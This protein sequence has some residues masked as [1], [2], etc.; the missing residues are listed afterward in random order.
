MGR[1]RADRSADIAVALPLR[2]Q[3]HSVAK[4]AKLLGWSFAKA[5]RALAQAKERTEASAV[6]EAPKEKEPKEKRKPVRISEVVEHRTELPRGIVHRIIFTS[7]QDDTPVHKPFWDN[8]LV[9]ANYLQAEIAVG[10]FT[11]QLGLFEDHNVATAVYAEEVRDFLIFERNHVGDVLFVADA[12]VLPTTSSPLNGWLTSNRGD[13]VV[14]PHARVAFESIPRASGDP[15]FAISTGTVTRPSYTPRAAGRKAIFHHTYGA[16]LC[17]V[18]VDGEC[19]F[20]HLLADEDG[21]FQDLDLYIKDGTIGAGYRVQAITWGDVHHEQLD[22]CIALASWG[23]DVRSRRKV[24]DDNL[25]DALMPKIQFLHDT[26]DFRRRNHHDLHDP[27]RRAQILRSGSSSV[28]EEIAEAVS[29]VNLATRTWCRTVVVESNHDAALARWLKNEE[30]AGDPDNA[31]YW[32]LMNYRWHRA[33]KQR[34]DDYNVVED[35]FREAGLDTSVEFV[36]SG[37]SYL[38]SGVEC[39]LHGDL[40]VGGSKGSPQQF[41]RLGPKVNSGHT[42]TPKIVDGVYVAG[43]SAKLEQGYN[44]GPTTWAHAHTVLYPNGKRCMLHLAAD[45]RWRAMAGERKA[46]AA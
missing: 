14:I 36:K 18:D 39:G 27:H 3:G 1:A 46:L 9:Y 42:H 30:G 17:E 22:P 21:S 19:F 38:V 6:V 2:E 16:L 7:A 13:H 43:V 37:G 26:L 20:R 28:E 40:G 44:K 35:A 23:Y 15:R 24:T 33:I 12:N 34:D 5:Q 32:H 4:V 31:D 10:G 25:L 8:L 45:G 11:Y 29:F 41:R